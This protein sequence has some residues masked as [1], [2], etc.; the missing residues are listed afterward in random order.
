MKLFRSF[1]LATLL[2]APALA[3]DLVVKKEKHSDA[4][5]M[6]GMEQPASD[7]TETLW[8]GAGRMRSEEGDKVTIVRAD[9]KKLYMLDMTAKTYTPIDLPFDMKKYMP[10]EMAPMM[11]Q[12]MGQVKV[13]VTPGTET[14]KIQDWNTTK[15][16]V[17]TSMGRGGS[18]TQ[19]MWVTKDVTLDF[20]AFHELYGAMLSASTF[21][22][23]TM[24][25]M[26]KIDGFAVLTTRTQKMMGSEVKSSEKVVSIETQEPP[27]GLYELPAGFTEKPFDPMAEMGGPGHARGGRAPR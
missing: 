14:Q 25:E 13:T 19:E 3:G 4:M 17:T 23:G 2:A 22:G 11:E 9:L 5:K 12:M 7:T 10:A 24:E 26:K 1:A 16:V 15:Y 27:A 20:A 6:P 18:S 21:G 8:I